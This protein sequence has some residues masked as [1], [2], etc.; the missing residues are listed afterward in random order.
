MFTTALSILLKISGAHADNSCWST[1][2]TRV[3]GAEWASQSHLEDTQN[4]TGREK[5]QWTRPWFKPVALE[6]LPTELSGHMHQGKQKE[7]GR[8]IT[9]C[10][11]KDVYSICKP[12]LTSIT[13]GLNFIHIIVVQNCIKTCVKVV[14]QGDH[15]EWG[16]VPC[17]RSKSYQVTETK[18]TIKY[19]FCYTSYQQFSLEIS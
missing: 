9:I 8:R 10:P 2:Y 4:V 15:L 16:A 18:Q 19:H 5:I 14:K 17:N 3:T 6:F 7:N 13:N 11:W 1:V 12:K